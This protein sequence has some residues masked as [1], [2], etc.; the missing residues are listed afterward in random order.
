M[1]LRQKRGNVIGALKNPAILGRDV[2]VA[3]RCPPKS[4]TGCSRCL[5]I[6]HVVPDIPA[7]RWPAA[8]LPSGEKERV[9]PW[10]VAGGCAPIDY[11]RIEAE[12]NDG[13]LSI[14]LAKARPRQINISE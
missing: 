5:S 4:H 6:G 11:D 13:F 2:T 1:S 12:Y 8:E 9:R 7:V 10:L 14:S 3:P